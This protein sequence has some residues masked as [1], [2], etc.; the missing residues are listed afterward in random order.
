MGCHLVPKQDEDFRNG[1]HFSFTELR[2]LVA[3]L[4]ERYFE[5]HTGYLIR[6][7]NK[8]DYHYYCEG[9]GK[10]PCAND[11]FVDLRNTNTWHNAVNTTKDHHP[12]AVHG[13]MRFWLA[14]RKAA[15]DE[16]TQVQKEK[17]VSLRQA[18]SKL[19]VQFRNDQATK[20]VKTKGKLMRVTNE[21]AFFDF[22]KDQ[23]N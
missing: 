10:E 9:D 8:G 23:S 13:I 4:K 14:A 6:K 18:E 1:H 7:F 21:H 11:V 19:E 5:L 22:Q 2:V 20:G 12:Y 3:F 16:L 15:Y 17:Y